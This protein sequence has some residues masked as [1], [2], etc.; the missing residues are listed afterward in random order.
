M[1]V[2]PSHSE[3]GLPM[4]GA[5]RTRHKIRDHGTT[6][7]RWGR[8]L[9]LSLLAR[10][11]CP[12][13]R[14]GCGGSRSSR[15]RTHLLRRGALGVLESGGWPT[16]LGRSRLRPRRVPSSM[17]WSRSLAADGEGGRSGLPSRSQAL[18][19]G[20]R[21]SGSIGGEA[22]EWVHGA[23]HV[24][25]LRGRVGASFRGTSRETRGSGWPVSGSVRLREGAFSGRCGPGGS[26][27][28]LL[29]SLG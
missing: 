27:D 10:R 9:T 22:A 13:Q 28:R 15:R 23:G 3:A 8:Q 26:A 20:V 1:G 6:R 21:G 12:I 29:E 16:P 17:A 5:I 2:L 4:P 19:N 7:D 11:T 24:R 18:R 14:R 25:L